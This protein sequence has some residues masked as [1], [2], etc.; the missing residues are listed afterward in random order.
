MIKWI[1]QD[2]RRI[3][4]SRKT[5]L[6]LTI[7][8]I[9]IL[10]FTFNNSYNKSIKGNS[11]DFL[12][13]QLANYNS[14]LSLNSLHEIKFSFDNE[15]LFNTEN[16]DTEDLCASY[17]IFSEH[18]NKLE[19]KISAEYS[20]EVNSPLS[21][22]DFFKLRLFLLDKATDNF[23]NYYNDQ[24][25]KLQAS[26]KERVIDFDKIIEIKEYIKLNIRPDYQDFDISKNSRKSIS[27]FNQRAIELYESYTSYENDLPIQ[28]HNTLT[29]SFFIA[30]YIDQFFLLLVIVAVLLIFDSF[31][32]DYKSGVI[33]TILS[34]PTKRYRY[35][36]MKT[37][38]T[39]ISMLVII[40]SP[41]LLTSIILYIK[42]GF[43]TSQYPILISRTT[44]SEFD[45]VL[46]YSKVLSIYKPAT[47]YSKYV[48]V[49][50]VG[51]VSQFTG[52][53]A[54]VPFGTQIDLSLLFNAANVQII[55]LAKYIF[56]LL[57]YFVLIIIFISTLN[58]LCSLIFNHSL[59][60]LVVLLISV[61]LNLFI[62]N[63]LLGNPLTNFIPFTFLSPT[64]LLM[65]TKPYT[66]YNGVITLV[67]WIVI[68][69]IITYRLLKKKDFTY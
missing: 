59:I 30:N 52:D 31:Y 40:I 12:N 64:A 13:E 54:D 8:I 36:V 1:I 6:L 42:N 17:F 55:I 33:K 62:N 16:K 19:K 57:L 67:V 20:E 23:I 24:N 50:R 45:P 34:A 49:Y 3:L 28:A 25:P 43:D 39:I 48:N 4:K 41:L 2:V 35:V 11:D 9:S 15:C 63:F 53:L 51:P 44:L 69:N 61:G 14:P 38:S 7:I 32:R 46:E 10:G 22:K 65:G 68:L 5:F 21:D 26:I 18:F 66:F 56:L 60:S 58:S 27:T 37:I 47:H 29:S